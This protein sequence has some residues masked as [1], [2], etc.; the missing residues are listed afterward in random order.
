MTAS[1]A[2][3][4]NRSFVL[5][6]LSQAV[7]QLGTSVSS[8]AY[9]LVVLELTGS[10]FDAGL[11]AATLAGTGLMLKVPASVIPTGVPCGR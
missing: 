10:A 3:R 7:S 11:V 4:R 8:L 6:W 2:L 5:L 9:P 1:T